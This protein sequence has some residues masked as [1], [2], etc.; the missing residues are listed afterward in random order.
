MANA[1]DD[2]KATIDDVATDAEELLEVE[3]KKKELEPTDPRAG[4]L[5]AKAQRIARDLVAKTTAERELVDQA[6]E[7]APPQKH[8]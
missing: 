2:L 4:G 8:N 3:E 7:S 5:S 1:R 6:R